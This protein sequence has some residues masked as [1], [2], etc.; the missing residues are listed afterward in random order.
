M[1][2]G[3]IRQT[4][5]DFFNRKGHKIVHSAPMVMKND[6]SLKFTN[7]GMNQFKD[8][9]L[10]NRKATDLR[11]ADT[12]KCLRVSGK[13][14]DLEEVG[15]DTY[16]HTM[17]EM[18]GNWSFG[19]YFK[20]EAIDWAYE[21]LVK[22]Y[23]IPSENLYVT[24]FGGDEKDGLKSDD[25]TAGLWK[26]Y[27]PADRILPFG[28]VDNFWEMGETGP[29]G[30]CTE[31]HIDLRTDAE[32]QKKPGHSLVN[33]SHPEVIEI[34]NLVFIQFNRN[35]DQT[36]AELP[37]KHV[38]TGMGFERLAMVLQGKKSSYDT[39]VFTPL[40]K[41]LEKASGVSY[42][43]SGGLSDVAFRVIADH[44]RAVSIAIAEGQ[45]PSNTGAG[46]VI[47][48][49][50]RRAIRYA[51]S[52]LGAKEPVIWKLLAALDESLGMVFPELRSQAD[53]IVKVIREEEESFLRTL[54][55]GIERFEKYLAVNTGI[56]VI[57]GRFAFELYD[58]YGFPLDL[59]ELLALEKKIMGG[60]NLEEFNRELHAQKDRSRAASKVD[61]GD[62][63]IL[64]EDEQEEFI[65]YDRLE[66][67]VQITRYRKVSQKGNERF[68]LVFNI[69]PFYA[70]SGGQVGDTGWLEKGADKIIVSDTKKENN[71]TIHFCDRLPA[72][73]KAVFKA[74]VDEVR[75][76][77]TVLNHSAT[78]LLHL[79][80]REIL[81][82]H[83]TQKGSLVHP[84]Y[85]RFDFSHFEKVGKE[86]LVKIEASVNKMI[87]EGIA[88]VEDRA[89]PLA[90]AKKQGAMALFG[91]KYGDLVRVVKFGRSLE[92]CGGTHVANTASIGSFR[93]ISEA[94]T[95]AGIRRIEA[96]TGNMADAWINERLAQLEEV[97]I[98]LKNPKDTIQ[99]LK[100]LIDE[101]KELSRKLGEYDK[102]RLLA[103]EKNIDEFVESR[104]D[105]VYFEKEVELNGDDMR[106]LIFKF[107]KKYQDKALLLHRVEGNRVTLALGLG[108]ILIRDFGLSAKVLI[109]GVTEFLVGGG[110]GQDHF[111][112][113][114]GGKPQGIHIALPKIRNEIMAAISRNSN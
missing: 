78:H 15:V 50:L 92:L 55:K 6:A 102:H 49:I 11:V 13:H 97:K 72:D 68:Q 20:K 29:C 86:E 58:T 40:I 71:V 12:Q 99:A 46:Y 74:K 114:T 7:A 113:A 42:G 62:W 34:W 104:I 18:L 107:I 63:I 84:D 85:L 33:T 38:D 23:K 73:P 26:K 8:Y 108:D 82:S 30:P 25:E 28:K 95:S 70:E 36:L 60:V 79:A 110:G 2:S 16:H 45:L 91:E 101:N 76:Q 105:E 80:L 19:D 64:K 89:M 54:D 66:A 31:I 83:V 51:Y 69:T 1:E 14:N 37:K 88:L 87:R 21:L 90:E 43:R 56:T 35:K 96:L 77:S 61:A 53:L 41:A 57:D 93:V 94:S 112:T 24:Y 109:N 32:K 103:M 5:L 48:R 98:L 39:D 22:V 3:L 106:N 100:K 81:G 17:F 59:T 47:R 44:V 4:F 75:R 52:G 67:E 10:G 27:F 111:A 9:F 65:G